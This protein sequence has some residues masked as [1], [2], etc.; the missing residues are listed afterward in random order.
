[1]RARRLGL[2]AGM[3]LLA[4]LAAL[5]FRAW[6]HPLGG[7][8]DADG[9]PAAALFG[10]DPAEGT[11][12]GTP[13]A[14]A[15]EGSGAAAGDGVVVRGVVVDGDGRPVDGAEVAAAWDGNRA[16]ARAT[17]GPDGRFALAVPSTSAEYL[18]GA[19]APELAPDVRGGVR[20]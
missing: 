13:G 8:G 15:D 20:P 5:L 16:P 4:V 17:T 10:P 3:L 7:P 2:A 1:M 9:G 11:G 14:G 12:E 19:R 6:R 18:V